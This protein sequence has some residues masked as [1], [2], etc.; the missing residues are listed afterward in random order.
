MSLA[1]SE[2]ETAALLRVDFCSFM[3]R[4]F[5]EL[6]SNTAYQHNWHLEVL[7]AKLQAVQSGELKRLIVM[8]PPRS[9]K[10]HCA[11]ICL[12]AFIL[13]HDPTRR[14]LCASYSQ[15]LASE[16]AQ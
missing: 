1:L 15:D 4:A 3:M 16:L 11:S 9:L 8:V 14:I 10:S 2:E 5:I 12:P 7:A 6:N 13:G